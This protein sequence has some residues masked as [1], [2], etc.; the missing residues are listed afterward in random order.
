MIVKGMLVISL[1]FSVYATTP[2]KNSRKIAQSENAPGALAQLTKHPGFFGIVKKKTPIDIVDID[3]RTQTASFVL[4]QEPEKGRG[5]VAFEHLSLATDLELT[6]EEL[7]GD[8]FKKGSTYVLRY[9]MLITNEAEA[10]KRKK[11]FRRK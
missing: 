2:A 8:D 6:V 11:P 3:R 5:V 9:D 10:L 7:N 1:G 4:S